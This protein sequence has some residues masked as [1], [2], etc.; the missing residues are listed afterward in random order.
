MPANLCTTVP[1]IQLITIV[2]NFQQINFLV[3]NKI[4]IFTQQTKSKSMSNTRKTTQQEKD[5][6]LYLNKLRNSGDTNMFGAGP[7]VAARF[8]IDKNTARKLLSLWMENFN[9]EG[10][11][12]T[13]KSN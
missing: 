5:A 2:N 13:V 8:G 12:E 4:V 11:Y 7:Y 10:D 9:E 1:C 3:T 6:F